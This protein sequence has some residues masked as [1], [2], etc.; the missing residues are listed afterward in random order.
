MAGT[1]GRWDHT[2]DFSFTIEWEAKIGAPKTAEVEVKGKK[3]KMF[4][5]VPTFHGALRFADVSH[6]QDPMEYDVEVLWGGDG[7][8]E[9]LPESKTRDLLRSL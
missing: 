3:Q 8:K 2:F 7:P 4:L 9:A 6:L 1:R 5:G